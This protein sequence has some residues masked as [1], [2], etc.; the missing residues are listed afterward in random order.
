MDKCPKCWHDISKFV[1]DEPTDEGG[2][3]FQCHYCKANLYK[4]CN[5][6]EYANQ[7]TAI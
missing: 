7:V 1:P 2:A 3:E 6:A 5:Y 4:H